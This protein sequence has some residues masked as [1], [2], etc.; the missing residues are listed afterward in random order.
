MIVINSTKM[1]KK[2]SRTNSGGFGSSAQQRAFWANRRF[3]GLYPWS[4]HGAVRLERGT[5]ENLDM[6]G[7]TYQTASDA[8]KSMRHK[9]GL[10][11]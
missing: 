5:P 9:T 7:M 2:R 6:F 3:S 10:N 4:S 8:Q 11:E 1:S